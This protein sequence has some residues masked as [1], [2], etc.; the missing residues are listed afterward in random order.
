[1]MANILIIDDE[2]QLCTLMVQV[3]EQMGHTVEYALTLEKGL[4]L[5]KTNSVEVVFLDV[6]LPDGDGLRKIPDFQAVPS[7]PEII[8]VTGYASAD[9]AEL[10]IRHNAWDYLIKPASVE[11]IRQT[12]QRALCYRAERRNGEAR[13]S[14]KRNGIIGKSPKIKSCMDLAARGANSDANILITGKTGTGKELFARAIHA[15]SRRCDKNFVVVDCGGLPESI[16]ESLLFGHVKGAFTGA[17]Q[18]EEGFIKHA[19]GGTLFLDEVG[20]LTL[21]MQKTFLR[22]LQERC[23]HP[24]GQAKEMKSDFR[25]VAAS[26][27]TLDEMVTSGQFRKDLLFRLRSITIDLPRLR[28][29]IEDIRELTIHYVETLCESHGI[30]QKAFSA[31]FFDVLESYRWPGNVR[32][33]YSALESTLTQ[34]FYEQTLFPKHLPTYVRI[35]V[36][37]SQLDETPRENSDLTNS[38]LSSKNLPQWQEFRKHHIAKGEMRYLHELIRLSGGNIIKAAQISGLSRPHLYGLL[39]KYDLSAQSPSSCF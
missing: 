15:N 13:L 4:R 30:Q 10:A 8:I 39:K 34:G 12:L 21:P 27:R 16:V 19:D 7:S 18:A 37:R 9:G 17:H 33:L 36:A 3:I 26:N 5:A 38:V 1:M 22:V 2:K 32:E 14:L 23:F 25:L 11:D 24:I 6:Q 31:D 20:E 29:R 28:E 35:Q